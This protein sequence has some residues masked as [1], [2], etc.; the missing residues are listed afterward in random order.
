MR[1]DPIECGKR[2]RALREKLNYTQNQF[3]DQLNV[4][5]DHLKSIERGRRACSLDLIA[6]ISI[7]YGESLDYLVLVKKP[8][9]AKAKI[10][11]VM[12]ILEQVRC[13]L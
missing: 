1:F 10:E 2:I 8:E 7:T 4:S 3:A 9:A 12:A 5:L 11:E 6:Q 13:E